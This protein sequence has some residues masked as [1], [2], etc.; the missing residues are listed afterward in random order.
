MRFISGHPCRLASRRHRRRLAY[1]SPPPAWVTVQ[2]RQHAA[3]VACYFQRSL[4]EQLAATTT[5]SIMQIAC[6]RMRLM[7]S[8]NCGHMMLY[9]QRRYQRV[10]TSQRVSLLQDQ[11]I[12]N[13]E[14]EFKILEYSSQTMT[15]ERPVINFSQNLK[16]L[17]KPR[18]PETDHH[19]RY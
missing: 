14:T 9:Q 1:G 15:I 13:L 3:C 5:S 19:A 2:R 17:A 10:A 6:D 7:R 8:H 12:K 18:Y 16:S 4:L 11:I